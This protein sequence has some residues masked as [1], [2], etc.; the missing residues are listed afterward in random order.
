MMNSV[1]NAPPT[2]LQLLEKRADALGLLERLHATLWRIQQI[3]PSSR[4]TFYPDGDR[5][6][7]NWALSGSMSGLLHYRPAEQRWTIHT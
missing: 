5:M 2:A 6:D 1:V 3:S 4:L 7:L